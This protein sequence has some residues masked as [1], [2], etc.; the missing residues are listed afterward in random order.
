MCTYKGMRIELPRVMRIELL[1]EVRIDLIEEMRL[2]SSPLVSFYTHRIQRRRMRL[3]HSPYTA[4]EDAATTCLTPWD[5]AQKKTLVKEPLV[6]VVKEP[7]VLVVVVRSEW[8][9][10]N[11]AMG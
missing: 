9:G 5:K 2:L 1:K 11:E 3:L 7:L 10:R 8:R 6:A 4:A